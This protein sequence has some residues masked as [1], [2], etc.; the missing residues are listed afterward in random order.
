MIFD[1]KEKK[2]YRDLED[3][4]EC[5]CLVENCKDCPISSY[6]NGKNCSC[7][8][9]VELYPDSALRLLRDRV[10]KVQSEAEIEK[11]LEDMEMENVVNVED[12]KNIEENMGI[13][14]LCHILGVRPYQGFSYEGEDHRIFAID[15]N[16]VRYELNMESDWSISYDEENLVKLIQHPE[17]IVRKWEVQEMKNLARMRKL[18]EK[19]VKF[20]PGAEV[21]T[22]VNGVTYVQVVTMKGTHELVGINPEAVEALE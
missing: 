21:V 12:V 6:N 15:E 14:P 9:F 13:P 2:L 7:V 19:L 4:V 16:G 5:N 22:E 3:W 11:E 17:K 18:K 10:K 8:E 20:L 1:M